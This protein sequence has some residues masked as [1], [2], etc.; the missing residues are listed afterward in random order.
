MRHSACARRIALAHRTI[1]IDRIADPMRL[2]V[3][4][5]GIWVFALLAFLLK[6]RRETKLR[7]GIFSRTHAHTHVD[8]IYVHDIQPGNL[9][10]TLTEPTYTLQGDQP[11]SSPCL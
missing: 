8:P 11:N 9:S 1:W 10:T 6:T 3:W 4:G 7:H 2:G 5:L